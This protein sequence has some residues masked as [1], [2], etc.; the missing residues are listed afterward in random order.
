MHT[1]AGKDCP[2]Y[3]ADYFRGRE[4]EE[5]RLLQEITRP[6]QRWNKSLCFSCP[7]PDIKLA[8][9]CENMQL[10][11]LVERPLFILKPRVVVTAYCT[12]ANQK[13]TEPEIGCGLCH[14]LPEIFIGEPGDPDTAA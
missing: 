12:K 5:C 4:Q 10:R 9:S 3:Y 11:A 1:P 13:V 7:V 6:P 2:Y 14:P 8:N